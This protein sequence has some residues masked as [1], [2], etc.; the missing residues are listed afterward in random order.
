MK[1]IIQRV[2]SCKLEV[3]DE[4]I[5]QVEKG[6]V[7]FLG[8]QKIDTKKDADALCEKIINL[9][10]FEDESQKMNLSLKD[11]LG[12]IMVVSNFTICAN[13]KR[14]RRPSFEDAQLPETA[15][16]LY[17]YFCKKMSEIYTS[18]KI[19]QGQFGSNM[20]ITVVND[21]PVNIIIESVDGKIN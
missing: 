15:R 10:I 16:E 18:Q 5:S 19:K 20:K 12:E 4:L 11:I 7:V 21:G 17:E 2:L 14:G 13:T 3:Q 6:L 9:R 1:A 8:I